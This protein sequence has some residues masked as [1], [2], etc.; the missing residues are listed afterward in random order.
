MSGGVNNGR[1]PAAGFSFGAAGIPTSGTDPV[2][3]CLRLRGAQS[4]HQSLLPD[5][6]I[7]KSSV[8][9]RVLEL[10]STGNKELLNQKVTR[11][12]RRKAENADHKNLQFE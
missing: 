6:R 4:H 10:L 2:T 8:V 1:E 11:V 12:A 7:N 3:V 5:G 9:I